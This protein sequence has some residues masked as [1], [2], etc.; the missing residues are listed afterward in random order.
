MKSVYVTAYPNIAPAGTAITRSGA[1]STEVLAISRAL[2]QIYRDKKLK[3][4][5]IKLPMRIVVTEGAQQ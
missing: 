2:K 1:G 5:R 3:G 4:K